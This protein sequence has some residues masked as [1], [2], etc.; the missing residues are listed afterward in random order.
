MDLNQKTIPLLS[1]NRVSDDMG[2]STL[3]SPGEGLM[4]MIVLNAA[5]TMSLVRQILCTFLHVIGIRWEEDMASEEYENET[6]EAHEVTLTNLYLQE[7]RYRTP[8]IRFEELSDLE[9]DEQ[10]QDCSVC[11]TQFE[12]KSEVNHLSCGHVFH[13]VCLE[14][15]VNHWNITCPLCR[16]PMMAP[17]DDPYCVP[18]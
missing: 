13:F 4:C 15:W 14:K 8:T 1:L 12:P 16:S 6:A 17:E 3:P 18:L 7:F 11:L 2:L 9:E 5:A 10:D